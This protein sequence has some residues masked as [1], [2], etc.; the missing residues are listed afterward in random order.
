MRLSYSDSRY[1]LKKQS[2]VDAIV[3]LAKTL[4]DCR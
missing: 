2:C 1:D 4:P 3:E